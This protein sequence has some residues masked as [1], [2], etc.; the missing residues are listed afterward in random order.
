MKKLSV[1]FFLLFPLTVFAAEL[2]RGPYVEDPTLTT[3]VVKWSTDVPAQ[4]WL[5]YGPKPK[6]GQIMTNSPEGTEH[7]VTLHGLASNKEYCYK[8]YVLNNNGDGVQSPAEGSFKTLYSPERKVVKFVIFGNTAGGGTL[9]ETLA[10]KASAHNPDFFI[11]T[12]NLVTDGL[13]SN[14]NSEFFG[15]LAPALLKAPMFIAVGEKEYGA[16]MEKQDSKNFFRQ[17]YSRFHSMTWSRGTP[18]YYYFDTA[19]ARFIF[20]DASIAS[21]AVHAPSINKDSAQYTWLKNSLAATESGKWKIVIMH[22][23]PYS[24]GEKGSNFAARDAFSNL[25]EYYGVNVVFQGEDLDYERT[26]PVKDGVESMRGVPY[27]TFGTGAAPVFTKREHKD[28]WTA[29]FFSGQV[30]GVGEIV[31]RKLTIRVYSLDDK[32]IETVEIYM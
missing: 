29:R 24:T 16:N 15:P 21:G 9:A 5:E 10:E 12:G 3:A 11:H 1:S 13:A 27:I 20:L 7:K 28:D 26:F 19:N 18:N 14:V 8:V 6:C 31:D 23:A 32:L 25:F 2:I 17:N 4:S 22:A 30:Y